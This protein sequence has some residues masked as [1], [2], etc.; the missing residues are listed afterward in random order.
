MFCTQDVYHCSAC[1]HTRILA[2]DA[3]GARHG[4]RIFGRRGA[5]LSAREHGRAALIAA[6]A[7]APQ[8]DPFSA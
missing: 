7:A 6:S 5:L 2:A 3:A 8:G 4:P 1:N